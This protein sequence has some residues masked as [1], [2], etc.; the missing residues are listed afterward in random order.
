MTVIETSA[1]RSSD[2]TDT[3]DFVSLITAVR[4]GACLPA[5][6]SLASFN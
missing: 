6:Q 1:G 3:H 5:Q 4:R 2:K